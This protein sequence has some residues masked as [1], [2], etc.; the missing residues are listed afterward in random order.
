[1]GPGRPML[2]GIPDV[3]GISIEMTSPGSPCQGKERYKSMYTAVQ[4]QLAS[5]KPKCTST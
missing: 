1:M 5:L 4:V 3:P 2:P